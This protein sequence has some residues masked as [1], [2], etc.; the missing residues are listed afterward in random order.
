M[1]KL[2][3]SKLTPTGN[4]ELINETQVTEEDFKIYMESQKYTK[5]S[6]NHY[7]KTENFITYVLTILE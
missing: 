1:I 3:F 5:K 4:I 6:K 7:E 2:Q